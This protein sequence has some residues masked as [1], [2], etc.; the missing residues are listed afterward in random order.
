MLASL[1]PLL[2]GALRGKVF[3]LPDTLHMLAV[4]DKVEAAHNS[5]GGGD[6]DSVRYMLSH[7]AAEAWLTGVTDLAQP[8]LW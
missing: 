2:T 4:L 5:I 3:P 8:P 6:A 1:R 7:N